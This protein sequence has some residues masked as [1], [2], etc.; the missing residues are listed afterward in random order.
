MHNI[1][2]FDLDETLTKKGTWGRFVTGTLKG[3]PWKW[4]PFILT[5]AFRQVLYMLKLAPR[6][7]VKESM[8][9][10]TISGRHK[11][12]LKELAEEFAKNEVENGLRNRALEVLNA[13]KQAGDR[14]LI[15]S[16][17]V[18]LIVE[19]IAKRLGIDE[20]V[21]T[22]MA[23]TPAGRLSRKIGGMNCY[24]KNKCLM[25]QDYLAQDPH[26]DRAKAQITVYSDSSS[27]L[28]LFEWA[29]KA[30]CVN[31]SPRLAKI[32]KSRKLEVQD[33]DR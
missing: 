8:M 32:A 17:A 13:H 16:A 28:P 1:V 26:F 24:G 7:H 30:I 23:Y 15:A 12:E 19:P 21:C 18:D 3:R 4:A 31:P 2:I 5:S 10:R 25:V 29:D 6:E 14:I 11:D 27:D 33:W 9:R 20:I 22:H